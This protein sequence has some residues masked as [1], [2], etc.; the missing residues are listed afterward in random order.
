MRWQSSIGLCFVLACAG[1]P[2]PIAGES[3]ATSSGGTTSPTTASV[4]DTSDASSSSSADATSTSAAS[5]SSEGEGS[6]ST[7][8]GGPL[9]GFEPFD[10]IDASPD[11]L[12]DRLCDEAADPADAPDEI[13][14][15]CRL[16]G[17]CQAP[18]TAPTDMLRVMA[19]N[20]E[21]GMTLSAQLAA[22]ADGS[23]PMPDILLVSEV[24]RGCTRSGDTNV[25]WDYAAALGMNHVYG[26]EFIELPRPG[27]AITATCEHGNAIFSKYPIGNVELLRHTVNESW[28]ETD[29]PRLGGRMALMA[30]IRV[31][32]RLLRVAAL[33]FESGVE[34]GPKRAAQAAEL[35]DALNAQA[36][37]SLAA[38]DTN[39]G[40]YAFD[41]LSGTHG[42]LTTEAFFE[43]GFVDA[44]VDLPVNGRVTH[45]PALVLDLI[46]LNGPTAMGS[47]VCPSQLC[48]ELSDHRAVWTIVQLD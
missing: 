11:V 14:I 7:T 46:L 48:D 17:S 33:H 9:P 40:L 19:W 10:C 18:D 3:G 15:H 45:P 28:Y 13:Y 25:A 44:H 36:N 34:D 29:E 35:A 42:E 41:L 21:R 20:V 2:S 16:E 26:V 12:V 23:L 4:D 31:G 22:F 38:G 32:D 47:E 43:R 39:A 30:D 24:D 5:T 6:D 27:D 37:P 1:D 8:G